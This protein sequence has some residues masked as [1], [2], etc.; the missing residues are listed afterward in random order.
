VGYYEAFVIT[1]IVCFL[2]YLLFTT[3]SNGFPWAWSN[4]ELIFGVLLSIIVGFIARNVLS[5]ELSHAQSGY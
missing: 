4:I 1:T 5:K 3:G 2:I